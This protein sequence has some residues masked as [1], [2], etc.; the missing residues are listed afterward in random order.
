MGRPCRALGNAPTDVPELPLGAMDSSPVQGFF[1]AWCR[2]VSFEPIASFLSVRVFRFGKT[3]ASIELNLRN[4]S[5]TTTVLSSFQIVNDNSSFSIHAEKPFRKESTSSN[6]RTRTDIP[7]WGSTST[8]Q[9]KKARRTNSGLLSCNVCRFI[10]EYG[11]L[12]F[13]R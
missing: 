11:F 2:F 10:F 13:Q 4:V 3:S 7:I 5:R 9:T 12:Q 8:A 1:S 6:Q